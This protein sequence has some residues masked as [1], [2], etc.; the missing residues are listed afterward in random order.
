MRSGGQFS[1]V[2]GTLPS[3]EVRSPA[4][5]VTT[6]PVRLPAVVF[7]RRRSASTFVVNPW[8]MTYVPVGASAMPC[9]SGSRIDTCTPSPIALF[10]PILRAQSVVGSKNVNRMVAGSGWSQ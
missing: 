6:H 5:T 3:A 4:V 7:T 8:K 1:N 10:V 9:P 2:N